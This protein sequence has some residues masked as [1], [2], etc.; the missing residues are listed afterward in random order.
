[1]SESQSGYTR[2]AREVWIGATAQRL[3]EA[4][5]GQYS[6]MECRRLA[7]VMHDLPTRSTSPGLKPH[8]AILHEL[9]RMQ[10]LDETTAALLAKWLPHLDLNR[11][12]MTAPIVASLFGFTTVTLGRHRRSGNFVADYQDEGGRADNVTWRLERV[13]REVA[14]DRHRDVG[15]GRGNVRFGPPGRGR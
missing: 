15:A 12:L 13:L 4:L 1:M 5:E 8:E 3:G 2:D 9:L 14:W 7:E 10:D 6:P 11:L